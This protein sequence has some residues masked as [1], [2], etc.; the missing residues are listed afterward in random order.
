VQLIEIVTFHPIPS[1]SLSP[2]FL[3]H[4]LQQATLQALQF[5]TDLLY[6]IRMSLFTL[7]RCL[8]AIMEGACQL[9][10]QC[11]LRLYL[12][13]N[14]FV[15]SAHCIDMGLYFLHPADLMLQQMV[16]IG[17]FFILLVF[18]FGVLLEQSYYL[19]QTDH[20]HLYTLDA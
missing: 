8:L 16:L 19:A 5:N 11:I 1:F 2:A 7:L 20:L 4:L 18:S 15:F 10:H 6:L 17:L 9:F 14:F 3:S 13:S 12:M